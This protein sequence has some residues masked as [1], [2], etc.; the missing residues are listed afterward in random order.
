MPSDD[1]LFS[2]H[3]MIEPRLRDSFY[4]L[5][6]KIDAAKMMS[7]DEVHFAI[8]YERTN[9]RL[10]LVTSVSIVGLLDYKRSHQRE[11]THELSTDELLKPVHFSPMLTSFEIVKLIQEFG[12]MI[13]SK[14]KFAKFFEFVEAAYERY[15][16][17]YRTCIWRTDDLTFFDVDSFNEIVSNS[18]GYS[19]ED[20]HLTN[21]YEMIV[22]LKYVVNFVD[23]SK[24]KSMNNNQSLY[25]CDEQTI[26]YR[27]LHE[28]Q[29]PVSFLRVAS[30][31]LKRRDI[32]NL[33][34]V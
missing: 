34:E 4:E 17:R 20:V 16:I 2:K 13:V 10:A 24:H 1:R 22:F 26:N 7:I 30:L 32:I 19:S 15:G 23:V 29:E 3:R 6:L 8:S 33:E 12:S 27:S 21:V 9:D 14:T 28:L 25:Y 11:F 18:D 5:L 31:D